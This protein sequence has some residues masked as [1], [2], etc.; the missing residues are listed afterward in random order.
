VEQKGSIFQVNS[1][2]SSETDDDD[3]KLFVIMYLRAVATLVATD[4]DS[5]TTGTK[6]QQTKTTAKRWQKKVNTELQAIEL[7]VKLNKKYCT[8]LLS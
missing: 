3:D 6:H 7:K 2:F 4:K 5:L 1:S 8:L